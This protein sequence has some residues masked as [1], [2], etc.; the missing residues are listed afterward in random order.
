MEKC[1]NLSEGISR[2]E[3][4]AIAVYA[5]KSKT[6]YHCLLMAERMI[7]RMSKTNK[8]ID[9]GLKV[10]FSVDSKKRVSPRRR[11]KIFIWM[12]SWGKNIKGAIMN[13]IINEYFF[14]LPCISPLFMSTMLFLAIQ[15]ILLYYMK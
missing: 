8:K 5:D 11:K 7:Q 3:S 13:R 10:K 15:E 14:K 9:E 4:P 2:I 12:N 6:R 1:K